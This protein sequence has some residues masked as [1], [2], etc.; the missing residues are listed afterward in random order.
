MPTLIYLGS[1]TKESGTT[2]CIWASKRKSRV[3]FS[4]LAITQ[5]AT[6]AL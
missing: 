2:K 6:F 1:D 4:R 5:A 3:T